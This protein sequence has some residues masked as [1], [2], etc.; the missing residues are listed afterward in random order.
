MVDYTKIRE[1]SSLLAGNRQI[2][3]HDYEGE[4]NITTL[5]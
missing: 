3:L 5:K 2:E 4:N 1:L